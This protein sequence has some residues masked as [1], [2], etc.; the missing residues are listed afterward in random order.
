MP[1]P[2]VQPMTNISSVRIV[3]RVRISAA[4]WMWSLLS[5][6]L[7]VV[8][9]RT[10]HKTR[11]FYVC[12]SVYLLCQNLKSRDNLTLWMLGNFACVVVCWFF[13]QINVFKNDFQEYHQSVKRFGSRSGLTFCRFWSGSKLFAIKIAAT[14]SKENRFRNSD[15][16]PLVWIIDNS[17]KIKTYEFGINGL[18]H[19]SLASVVWGLVKLAV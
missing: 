6:S 2:L 1:F 9:R 19:I 10:H 5:S 18:T 8:N 16:R 17:N 4:P 11:K 13:F 15:L 14:C 3:S 7:T 12:L